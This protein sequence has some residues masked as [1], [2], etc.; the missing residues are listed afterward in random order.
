MPYDL[1]TIMFPFI[2]H[3]YHRA[4]RLRP[5]TAVMFTLGMISILEHCGALNA[6]G[7]I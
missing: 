3:F 6:P 4:A 7:A 2:P 5:D 1:I